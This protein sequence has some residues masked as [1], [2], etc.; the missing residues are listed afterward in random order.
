MNA[1]P[2]A[3]RVFSSQNLVVR[4]AIIIAALAKAKDLWSAHH[5]HLDILWKEGCAWNA[6]V[7]NTMM[8]PHS[9]AGHALNHAALAL[10][11]DHWH[12]LDVQLLFS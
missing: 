9:C 6:W 11:Q 7:A 4:N 1:I 5:V 10:G 8:P 12:A 2:S 3:L